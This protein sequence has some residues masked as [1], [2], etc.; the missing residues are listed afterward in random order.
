MYDIA[1]LQVLIGILIIEIIRLIFSII[2][3]IKGVKK[4]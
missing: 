3:K 1:I 4:K 2:S